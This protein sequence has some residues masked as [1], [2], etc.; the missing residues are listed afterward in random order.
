MLPVRSARLFASFLR[1]DV[2]SQVN[3]NSLFEVS[4]LVCSTQA[5]VLTYLGTPFTTNFREG[6]RVFRS[7]AIAA[8]QD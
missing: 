3:A 7:N 8:V 2:A 6:L 1:V 4:F 5:S